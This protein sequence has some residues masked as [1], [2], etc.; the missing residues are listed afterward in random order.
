MAKGQPNGDHHQG[1]RLTGISPMT[2]AAPLKKTGND[3]D[4][5][6]VQG[7]MNVTGTGKNQ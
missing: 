2:M 4:R 5:R 6:R 7:M 3:T 1:A